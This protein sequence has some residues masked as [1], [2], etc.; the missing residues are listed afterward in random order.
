[1]NELDQNIKMTKSHNVLN[2]I[3]RPKCKK[4]NKL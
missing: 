3:E 1:M 4:N 2:E